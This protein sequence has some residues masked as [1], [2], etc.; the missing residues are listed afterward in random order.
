MGIIININNN[1]FIVIIITKQSNKNWAD[2]GVVGLPCK[3]A[4]AKKNES[5]D[6]WKLFNITNY[7]TYHRRLQCARVLKGILWQH[8]RAANSKY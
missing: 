8:P 4:T 7:N 6:T 1:I 2:P 3:Y 5:S